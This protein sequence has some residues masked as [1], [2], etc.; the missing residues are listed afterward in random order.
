MHEGRRE[1]CFS[2]P[3]QCRF[4]L[5]FK[6]KNFFGEMHCFAIAVSFLFI[7]SVWS[8]QF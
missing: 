3:K 5:R 6:K 4:G 2:L 1:G 7:F 8:L